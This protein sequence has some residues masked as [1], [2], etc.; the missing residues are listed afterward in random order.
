MRNDYGH[1]KATG[2]NLNPEKA[3]GFVYLIVEKDTKRKYI[4]L[5][6]FRGAGKKNKGQQ[7]NWKTYCSSSKY[8]QELIKER[9]KEQ[10]DFFILDQYY[11]KGGLSFAEIWTQV[12]CE[13]LSKNDEFMNRF[14]D[15]VSWKVT[16]PVTE[17]HKKKLKSLLKKYE[18]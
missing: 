4:G 16:E 6:H 18:Y 2:I 1:W 11:T 5:K 8:L 13:C 10:F 3:I 12:V 9:G 7:S 14:I 15:K 17:L